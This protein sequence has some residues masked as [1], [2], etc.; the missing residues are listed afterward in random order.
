[1]LKDSIVILIIT[2][3][4]VLSGVRKFLIMPLLRNTKSFTQKGIIHLVRMQN[5]PEDYISYPLIRTRTCA[6]QG[7]R[8]V[9]SPENFVH[10]L[11]G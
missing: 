1:M 8:N 11:D 6:Y 4:R 5:F 3:C 7:V 2:M 10:A 9:S